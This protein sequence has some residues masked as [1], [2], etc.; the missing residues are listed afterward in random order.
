LI[1]AKAEPFDIVG[2]SVIG[3]A[4]DGTIIFWNEAAAELYGW[5]A[6]DVLGR[7]ILDVTPSAQ[8]REHAA[9]IMARLC[10][11]ETWSGRFLVR[12][13]DGRQFLAEVRDLPVFDDRGELAGVLGISKEV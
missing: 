6:S 8:L 7:N 1:T 5:R 10:V 4:P 12:R 11:G 3:T 2:Q 13:R 9:A